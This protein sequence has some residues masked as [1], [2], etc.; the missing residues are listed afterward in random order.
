LKE[1]KDGMLAFEE[2]LRTG[3]EAL[4]QVV[5]I[6]SEIFNVGFTAK[7]TATKLDATDRLLKQFGVH[8]VDAF[9]NA[10]VQ[11]KGFGTILLQLAQE[12]EALIIKMV[13]FK[14]LG[15]FIPGFAALGI[16]GFASGGSVSAG[17]P[18]IVGEAGPELFIPGASGSI[19][20]NGA[21]TSSAA[22]G[23]TTVN[24]YQDFRGA[25]ASAVPQ[26]KAAAKQIEDRAVARA[27]VAVR[28]LSLRTA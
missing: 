8:A 7:V 11:G 3:P 20:P 18:I 21:M 14:T 26:I 15:S 16:P 24:L 9:A 25:D 10:I 19:V 28:E 4:A 22:G 6:N 2:A 12:V 17:Q 13:L 5:A 23:G 27:M 1:L